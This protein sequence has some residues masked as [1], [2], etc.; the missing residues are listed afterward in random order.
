[1]SKFWYGFQM[2]YS[3]FSSSGE[4]TT[5][6]WVL[7]QNAV[8]ANHFTECGLV[9]CCIWKIRHFCRIW[10]I[11]IDNTAY[12]RWK[13]CAART[14]SIYNFTAGTGFRTT[15]EQHTCG[16]S[17]ISERWIL[18]AAHCTQHLN[19]RP[20]NL[21]VQV[22]AT[23]LVTDGEVHTIE[24]V[25]NHPKYNWRNHEYDVSLLELSESLQWNEHVQP[26]Q[27]AQR[28]IETGVRV[29]TSGWGLTKVSFFTK[30]HNFFSNM[31]EILLQFAFHSKTA[32]MYRSIDMCTL[33]K[34]MNVR[35]R[36]R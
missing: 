17:I 25:I 12:L 34:M 29:I 2:W 8:S 23:N 19:S 9:F 33:W 13:I 21:R 22:G 20:I 26:I 16:G 11:W 32:I 27:L 28:F 35:S 5:C 4:I 6:C 30:F 3:K 18:T 36:P 31:L 15:A 1:M 24:R 10:I 14:I 7:S